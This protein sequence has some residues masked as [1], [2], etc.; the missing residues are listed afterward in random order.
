MRGL[1]SKLAALDSS[2]ERALRIIEFFDQLVLHQADLEA[3]VRATAV[4]TENTAGAVDDHVGSVSVVASSGRLLEPAE[5]AAD[6]LVGSIVVDGETVGRVW[7][8][9]SG[10]GQPHEWDD[11]ILDR[12][13]LALATL[14]A[15]QTNATT[16]T[17]LGLSDPAVL[18]ILL[19][20]S[21]SET[22][23]SRAAR[24]LGFGVGQLVRVMAVSSTTTGLVDALPSC[25][26]V[27]A[28]ASGAR[29]TAA[30]ISAE[31]AVLLIAARDVG[32]P[33]LPTGI[34]ACVG[35]YVPVEHCSRSWV[36]AHRGVKFAALGGS[37]AAMLDVDDIGCLLALGDLDSNAVALL[38]DV[39]AIGRVAAGRSGTIDLALID[40][41]AS[42]S[43]VREAASAVFLHHSSAAYRVAHIGET[44]GLNL[45]R[46]DH[47]YRARTAL[48]LW[49]LHAS[50]PRAAAAE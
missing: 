16:P 14:H 40:L 47:Q 18:H 17:P 29:T 3:V 25:R 12:M 37:W 15:R 44:L 26:A 5:P 22:E 23:A 11:L 41:L 39:Q 32:H 4:L 31:L 1:L 35:P 9:R 19:R 43:S 27:V 13:A 48:L 42:T 46:P 30:A 6:A 2:A 36:L 8:D 50:T 7:L 34:V 45:R 21:T 20:E 28:S 24:L 49:Q 10:R 38:P 33:E